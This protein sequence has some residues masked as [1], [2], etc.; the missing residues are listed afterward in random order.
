MVLDENEKGVVSSK[1]RC[2]V[3]KRGVRC[4]VV[5]KPWALS[6]VTGLLQI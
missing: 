3:L 1:D 2:L 4:L 5:E 6:L